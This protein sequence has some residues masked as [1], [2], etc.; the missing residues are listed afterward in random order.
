MTKLERLI[1]NYKEH[2]PHDFTFDEEVTQIIKNVY[3]LQIIE[4]LEEPIDVSSHQFKAV[5]N[6]KYYEKNNFDTTAK[7]ELIQLLSAYLGDEV[8][9]LI[10]KSPKPM[11]IYNPMVISYEGHFIRFAITYK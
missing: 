4:V 7:K 1:Q 10:D 8:R 5:M 6:V 3:A 9:T 2:I 11:Y